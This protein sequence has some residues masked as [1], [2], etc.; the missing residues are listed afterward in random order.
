VGNK[1]SKGARVISGVHKANTTSPKTIDKGM[2]VQEYHMWEVYGVEQ[3]ATQGNSWVCRKLILGVRE[4]K[5]TY[6]PNFNTQKGGNVKKGGARSEV[7]CV[8]ELT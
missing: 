1:K 5:K 6:R 8:T 4:K 2:G 7:G 3:L